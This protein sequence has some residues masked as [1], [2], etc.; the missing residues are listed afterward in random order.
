M[1]EKRVPKKIH[2]IGEEAMKQPVWLEKTDKW[3]KWSLMVR[4][5]HYE[6]K[7]IPYLLISNMHV[8]LLKP[9]VFPKVSIFS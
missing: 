6:V 1:E 9:L 4:K 2:F 8:Q 3:K 7:C 5:A